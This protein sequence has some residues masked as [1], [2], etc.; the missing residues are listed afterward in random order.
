MSRPAFAR[1]S[2]SAAFQGL[3]LDTV[4]SFSQ[5]A[6]A[7]VAVGVVLLVVALE[8]DDFGVALEGQNVRRHSVKEPTVV[9]NDEHTTRVGEKRIL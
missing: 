8:Q 2:R 7:F 1:F 4:R 5:L 9:A 3:V 6:E